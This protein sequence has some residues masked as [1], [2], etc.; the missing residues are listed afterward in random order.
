[1]EALPPLYCG[2]QTAALAV[3]VSAHSAKQSAAAG[4]ANRFIMVKTFLSV[5]HVMGQA[6]AAA[7][8]I[9]QFVPKKPSLYLFW[10]T[11]LM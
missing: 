8:T 10:Q 2:K 9:I 3:T 11:S 5:V 6:E 1:M 4:A 7:P